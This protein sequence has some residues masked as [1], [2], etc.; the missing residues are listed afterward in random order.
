VPA[1]PGNGKEGDPVEEFQKWL[2]DLRGRLFG[3]G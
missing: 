2:E 3:D 1:N